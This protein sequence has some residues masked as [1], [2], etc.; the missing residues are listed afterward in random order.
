[1]EALRRQV[2]RGMSAPT[3]SMIPTA[4]AS[5]PEL[6]P[7][8]FAFDP[9]RARELLREAGYPAG[10]DL[11]LTCPNNRYVND[12]RICMA[13]AGMFAKVGVRTR[14]ET[15]PR[16]QFFQKVDQFDISMHLYGWG[17]AAVDPGFTL[18]PV[19]R[20]RDG[21]G[22]GDFN[23]GRY[24]DAE[25]DRLIDAV[26]VEMDPAKRRDLMLQAFRRTRDAIHTIPLHR[27]MIPWAT[28]ANVTVVHR[29]DNVVEALWVKVE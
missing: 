5:F 19:L 20:G 3:G 14:L 10:F 16:A 1:M 15:M 8:L 23:T 21:H 27:Q 11:Q 12:E 28:R 7:R 24:R 18:T 26:E 22:K 25:L 4:R 2:M 9:V 6:E 29:P 13:L 17:G